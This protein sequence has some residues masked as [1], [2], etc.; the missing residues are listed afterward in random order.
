ME[1]IAEMQR[2]TYQ[3]LLAIQ[4]K[5]FPDMQ[6]AGPDH[7]IYSKGALTILIGTSSECIIEPEKPAI[8]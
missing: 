1:R 3:E 6:T 7:W 4:K 8:D 2:A 5:H